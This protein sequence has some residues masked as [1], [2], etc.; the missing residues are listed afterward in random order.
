[1]FDLLD[2][3]EHWPLLE[4]EADCPTALGTIAEA[5]CAH[6]PANIKPVIEGLEP[7]LKRVYDS[8]RMGAAAVMA[9]FI[10]QR[11]V[12]FFCVTHLLPFDYRKQKLWW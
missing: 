1:M 10:N 2:E 12:G 11:W 4:K 8:Q 9:E 3:R 5:L 7:M 6:R